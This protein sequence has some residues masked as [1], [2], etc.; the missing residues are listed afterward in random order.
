[1]T[2]ERKTVTV[3]HTIA[4]STARL[5]EEIVYT[6]DKEGLKAKA[7]L[8]EVDEVLFDYCAKSAI[9]VFR[10]EKMIT[11]VTTRPEE[12]IKLIFTLKERTA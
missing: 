7:K 6:H 1:M 5:D 11:S 9:R 4:E 2:E 3:R 8:H 10:S 12:H